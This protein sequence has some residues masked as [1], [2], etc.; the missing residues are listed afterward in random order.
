V[1]EGVMV[2]GEFGERDARGDAEMR[3]EALDAHI[4]L[5]SSK[6]LHVVPMIELHYSGCYRE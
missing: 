3:E 4:V 2:Y 6:R 5:L 1:V